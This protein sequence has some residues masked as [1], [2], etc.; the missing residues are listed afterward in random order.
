[1]IFDTDVAEQL[2][3]DYQE[4]NDSALG[5]FLELASPLMEV[6]ALSVCPAQQED[7]VQEAHLKSMQIF[8]DDL[9]KPGRGSMYTFLSSALKF[10][11]IDVL[12]K[13]PREGPEED[14]DEYAANTDHFHYNLEIIQEGNIVEYSIFRYPTLHQSVAEDATKYVLSTIPENT[15][16]GS[17]GIIRTLCLMY[18]SDRQLSRTL[19]FGT[20][21]IARMDTLGIEW[22]DNADDALELVGAEGVGAGLAADAL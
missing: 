6:I 14:C 1:M 7:L 12:R 16:E 10:H 2:Y 5:E 21:A 19:Y 4:G 13:A 9:Y 20:L 15:V 8:I 17:R 3:Q 11:M 22:Q 18:N